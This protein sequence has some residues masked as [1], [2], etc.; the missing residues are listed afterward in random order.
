MAMRIFLCFLLFLP[1]V[2]SADTYK[3]VHDGKTTLSTQPCGDGAVFQPFYDGINPKMQRS[4][5]NV[6]QPSVPI[7]NNS[8]HSMSIILSQ[9]GG[10][11]LPGTVRGV[12]VIYQVDTGASHVSISQSVAN[13]AGI[14]SCDRRAI[15]STANGSV[16]VCLTHV[17]EITFG[18][19]TMKNIEV[20]I[21]PDMSQD[22][23]LGMNVLRHFNM[24]QQNG[25]ILI[26]D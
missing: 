22:V 1:V 26:S 23:L 25:E 18:I 10:Y 7:Q 5:Q 24:T 8:G 3:C 14:Y 9:N 21:Q 20:S 4:A 17:S 11:Y 6:A 16:N 2:V 15:S 13:R 12:P 19:F